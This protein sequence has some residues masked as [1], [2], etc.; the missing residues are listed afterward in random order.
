MVSDSPTL[1]IS[2]D[3]NH[4][5]L[6]ACEGYMKSAQTLETVEGHSRRICLGLKQVE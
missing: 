3:L 5:V 2:P 4:L 1:P 6:F